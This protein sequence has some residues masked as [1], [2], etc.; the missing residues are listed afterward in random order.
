MSTDDLKV[1]V[2][3]ATYR[4]GSGL[5]RLVA[6]LDAQTLP[7]TEWEVIFVD[8]GSPDD[9][10]QRLIEIQKTRPHVRL[11]RIENSGWPCRPRN[12]GTD[13]ARG[14][15]IAYMD[16]DDELYPD[17]LRVGYEFA[18]KYNADV[19]NGKEARTHDSGWAIDQYREDSGQVIDR[20]DYHPLIPTNPHKLYRRALLQEHGIRFRE[21]GRVLWEDIFFNVLVAQH[22]KVIATMASTPYY[23][24]FATPGS[25]S[26]TF[27]RSRPEWWFW[28]DEVV[29]AID[30]DLAGERFDTQRRLLRVHQYRSR[31]MDAFNNLYA[32][33]PAAERKLIFD[34]AHQIQSE[35][36]P[37]SDDHHLNR[38]MAMRAQLLRKGYRH[39]LERLTVDDPNIPGTARITGANWES[40]ILRLTTSA[41]WEDPEG[42]R[43]RLRHEDGRFLKDLP[44]A[45]REEFPD[46]MFDVTDEIRQASVEVGLRSEASRITWMA[47]SSWELDATAGDGG[48]VWGLTG[49]A[50]IDPATGALGRPLDRGVWALNGRCSL[51]GTTQHRIIRQSEHLAPAIHF[52]EAGMVAVYSRAN[53]TV[54]LDFDQ[55]G[56]PVTALVRFAGG[57]GATGSITSLQITGIPATEDRAFATQL[58]INTEP[59]SLRFRRVPRRLLDRLR[60]RDPGPRGWRTVPA[61]LR[62]A[63]GRATIE[64]DL[65]DEGPFLARIGE[66]VPGGRAVISVAAGRSQARTYHGPVRAVLS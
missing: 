37:K 21:G 43:H 61:T 39:L 27:V 55:T 32:G 3:V 28:L 62:I 4:S 31:L 18:K 30:S 20:T 60:R 57:V 6:S 16:H 35:R 34:K 33:R 17:A 24:W 8:D 48:V 53:D 63:S 5:D 47:D 15:Y 29:R 36:F 51:A 58:D 56:A 40:G 2:V 11:E 50:S 54:V 45:Y 59:L 9:T 38:T 46:E 12:V 26:T 42:R 66:R 64:V 52:D 7:A 49:T 14:E 10:Y 23:H 41:L 19:V 44:D 22:A 25:G 13:L 1:S 65:P